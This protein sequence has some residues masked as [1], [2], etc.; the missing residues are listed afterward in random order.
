MDA[1]SPLGIA[2]FVIILI[3]S[4]SLRGSAG[5]G[6]LN[7][8]LLMVVLPA[9]VVVPA[10][11][12]LGILSSAAI[13][14]HDYRH[15]LWSAV[16][17]TLPYGIAGTAA[18]LFLF[19]ALDTRQ[20]EKG[21][22]LFI[23]V[24]GLYSLWRLVLPPKPLRVAPGVIAAAMGTAS[25]V[26]GTMFGALAGI[27]VAVFLDVLRLDKRAFRVTMAA[28]LMLM[29]IA[30]AGGYISVGAVTRE[31][32]ITFAAALPLMGIGVVLGNRLHTGLNQM[33]FYRLIALLFV[34][35]GGFLFVR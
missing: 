28:T 34:V 33:G 35:I 1:L 30:R 20:L 17:Q 24:Y 13:V 29:G 10:L 3:V 32:M 23:L 16:R 5:F 21:L 26:I 6:G 12:F 11:V 7:G 2:Y 4:F 22:G 19:D 8:P 14:V 25:G 15:I 27:F 18:G 31:V 9:K